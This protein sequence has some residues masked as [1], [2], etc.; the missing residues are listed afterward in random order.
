[1][2]RALFPAICACAAALC[3]VAANGDDLS[4]KPRAGV[5]LLNN[6]EL[7]A[8]TIIAAGDRYD[9]QLETGEIRV[10]RSDVA[11]VC[12]DAQDCYQKKR[13]GIEPD[14]AQDHVDLAEWCVKNGLLDE[15]EKE[16]AAARAADA[17]HPKI[18]LVEARL[19]LAR[20]PLKTEPVESSVKRVAPASLDGMARNLPPGTMEHFTNTIQPMLLNH[21]AKSGCHAGRGQGGLQLERIHPK[22]AGRFSTQRNLRRVLAQLDLENPQQSKLLQAPIRAHGPAAMP[23]FTDREQSQY[24][25]LVE[26]VYALAGTRQQPPEPTLAERTAPLLQAVPGASGPQADENEAPS[27]LP[28]ADFG[29]AELPEPAARKGSKIPTFSADQAHTREE[30]RDK[31]LLEHATKRVQYGPNTPPPFAPK[32]P[33]DPEIFNRRFFGR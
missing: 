27:A 14:V 7:I 30:L 33:F 6:G 26:W 19:A 28:D 31:G 23:I 18:R 11:M 25:Q 17:A 21:C 13:A 3:A 9:V 22:L 24:R 5:L 10:K 32:D 8:G 2:N 29:A 12:R 1:M 20:E 4:I 16:L 15:G